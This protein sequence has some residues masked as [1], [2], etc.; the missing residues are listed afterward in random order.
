MVVFYQNLRNVFFAYSKCCG[1]TEVSRTHPYKEEIEGILYI[2]G[3][4]LPYKDGSG[5]LLK[6]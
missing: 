6:E 3:V 1:L 4:F 5:I 2:H